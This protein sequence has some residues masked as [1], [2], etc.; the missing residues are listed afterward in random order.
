MG[1]RV[2]HTMVPTWTIISSLLPFHFR[3]NYA[4]LENRK[5]NNSAII[6]VCAADTIFS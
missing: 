3:A 4:I 6:V 1:T 2:A 5:I